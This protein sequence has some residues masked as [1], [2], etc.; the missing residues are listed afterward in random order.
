MFNLFIP[1][2]I[3]YTDQCNGSNIEGSGNSAKFYAV[4][5]NNASLCKKKILSAINANS[6]RKFANYLKMI[7]LC[8]KKKSKTTIGIQSPSFLNEKKYNL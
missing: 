4:L 2:C 8:I 7:T 5:Y 3:I 1:K 6:H